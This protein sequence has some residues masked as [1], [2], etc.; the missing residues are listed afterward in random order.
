METQSDKNKQNPDAFVPPIKILLRLFMSD[1]W[2]VLL[3]YL[4]SRTLLV[5]LKGHQLNF[6]SDVM[7]KNN[8]ICITYFIFCKLFEL[9]WWRTL[10]LANFIIFYYETLCDMLCSYWLKIISDRISNITLRIKHCTVFKLSL[11]MLMC[12]NL[13]H[14]LI[15]FSFLQDFV[16]HY[17]VA[18]N[19]TFHDHMSSQ[20]E[21]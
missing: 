15:K 8:F 3:Y 1:S 9:I 2:P 10:Q 19:D 16:N 5:L 17:I 12:T 6:L 4:F 18:C 14:Y 11:T 13:C 7:A 20:H 21:I